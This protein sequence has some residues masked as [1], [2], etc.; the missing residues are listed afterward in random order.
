MALDI[1]A[2]LYNGLKPVVTT[3][4]EPMALK[5]K[6]LNTDQGTKYNPTQKRH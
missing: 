3:L 5:E 1:I 2:W 6:K 4:V